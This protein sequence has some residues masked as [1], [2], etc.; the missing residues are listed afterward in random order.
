MAIRR[1]EVRAFPEEDYLF[2]HQVYINCVHVTV[3]TRSPVCLVEGCF[4][5]H[6][7]LAVSV[8]AFMCSFLGEEILQ[9]KGHT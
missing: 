8:V 2:A 9:L 7:P 3:V 4:F 5:L 6:V 1:L